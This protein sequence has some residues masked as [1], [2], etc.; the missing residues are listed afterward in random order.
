MYIVL[1]CCVDAEDA[2]AATPC[3]FPAAMDLAQAPK[4]TSPKKLRKHPI[5]ESGPQ[6][7]KTTSKRG[8][9]SVSDAEDVS[10][11]DAGAAKPCGCPAAMDSAPAPK[12]TSLKKL[13]KH[14]IQE[15]GPQAKINKTKVRRQVCFLLKGCHC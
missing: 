4:S 9:K 14:P 7:K 10:A 15:S 2:G 8:D 11:E 6:E 5:Q 13:R 1:F 12:A 3:S